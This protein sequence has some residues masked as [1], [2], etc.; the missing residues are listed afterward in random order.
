MFDALVQR[1]LTEVS[2][3]PDLSFM[4]S[5]RAIRMRMS[6]IMVIFSF[7]MCGLDLGK[8]SNS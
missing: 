5:A 4:S 7:R 3:G 2:V 1:G 8:K 6:Q